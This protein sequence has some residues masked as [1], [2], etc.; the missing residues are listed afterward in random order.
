MPNLRDCALKKTGGHS[1]IKHGRNG[2]GCSNTS[3]VPSD[4]NAVIHI[5]T[6]NMTTNTRP[7]NNTWVIKFSKTPLTKAQ[8]TGFGPQVKF[9]CGL[10]AT[11]NWRICG[12]S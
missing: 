5:S 1:N 4:L 9:C 10:K 6:L 11:A 7:D 12:C 8:E 2:D 3:N